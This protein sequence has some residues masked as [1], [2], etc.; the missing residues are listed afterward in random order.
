MF[1]TKLM[2][3]TAALLA[4]WAGCS[5]GLAEVGF[6][7]EKPAAVPSTNPDSQRTAAILDTLET[8][9]S[10]AALNGTPLGDV[11]KS[12]NRAT[13][14]S[15][16]NAGLPIYVDP[17]GLQEAQKTLES[18]ITLNV[19]D[20]PLKVTL[21]RVLAQ[22]GLEYTVKDE[23]LFIVRQTGSHGTSLR[24]F[25]CPG[26]SHRERRRSWP[27]ST[28]RSRCHSQTRRRWRIS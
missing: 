1:L 18:T 17:G 2:M 9:V 4:V 14:K 22:V 21:A 15:P 6:T 8:P 11:L 25:P 5:L 27:S 26:S 20:M 13:R 24:W 12:I 3:P 16:L 23:I 10:M 7:Q 28:C 19:N